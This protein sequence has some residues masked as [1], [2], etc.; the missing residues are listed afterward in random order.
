MAPTNIQ[1]QFCANP[2]YFSSVLTPAVEN[3]LPQQGSLTGMAV[4]YLT[5][6]RPFLQTV[7]Q[8]LCDDG[9][10]S[11]ESAKSATSFITRSATTA[12]V[13]VGTAGLVVT[14]AVLGSPAIAFG[15]GVAGLAV[16]PYLAEKAVFGIAD[17]AGELLNGV[18]KEPS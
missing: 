16:L 2:N 1:S 4:D 15:L 14:G 5:N 18:R 12:A 7:S 10:M 6:T 11:F 13:T 17:F 9:R 8:D 3:R